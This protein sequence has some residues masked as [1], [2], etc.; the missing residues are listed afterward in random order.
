MSTMSIEGDP[1]TLTPPRA[2]T[3]REIVG[4]FART[5]PYIKPVVWH[6]VAWFSLAMVIGFVAGYISITGTDLFNN[7]VL[8]GQRIAPAQAAVL[9]VDESYVAD[10][11]G[12]ELEADDPVSSL[13][14]GEDVVTEPELSAEQR[15]TVRNR[16]IIYAILFTIIF[17]MLLDSLGI[18][19]W[20]T[21]ISQAI[22]QNL[23]VK[24]I[25]NA[26]HLSVKHQSHARTG[27]AI[28][29]VFQD[30]RM[31]SNVIAT[32]IL[33]PLEQGF[34]MLGAFIIVWFF[35]PTLGFMMIAAMVPIAVAAYWWTPRIQRL[36][37]LSRQSNSNVTSRI[38][39]VAQGIRVLKANQAEDIALTRFDRDS[40]TALDYAYYLRLEIMLYIIV[41][42]TITALVLI[43]GDYLMADWTVSADPTFLGGLFAFVLTYTLWNLGAFQTARENN[44]ELM[45][46]YGFM[47]VTW[48]RAIDMA[49][50]LNRAY[51]LLDLKPGV[52]EKQAADEFPTPI[53]TV[54]YAGVSFSYEEDHPVL[55]DVNLTAGVGTVTAIVGNTGSGKSTLTSLLLRLYDPDAGQITI[56][57]VDLRDMKISSIRSNVSIALQ[58]NVLFAT[59]VSDNIGYA[60]RDVTPERIREAARIACA[61]EFIEEMASGYDTELGERGGKLSTGQRQRLSIARAI[62]RDTPIL[63]LDEP[64]ASL[65][66]ETEQKVLGNLAEWGRDRVLFVITHRLST[67]QGADQIAFLKDGRITEMGTHDELM[68]VADGDY[69][70]FV[71]EETVGAEV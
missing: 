41:I 42:S 69:R 13:D 51:Y 50:G 35:S 22:N 61:D 59:S 9:F 67:I 14:D 29:R 25:E 18:V 32:V 7:A 46:K 45:G 37:W 40:H 65:D 38:Q 63:I 52:E 68:A 53:N 24:M 62:V 70:A 33:D 34:G 60:A 6:V 4:L 15:K 43:I 71:T 5:W 16:L 19:F 31:I 47:F 30:S 44:G 8:N 17:R 49:M 66:A 55:R 20:E 28:Y 64:T 1:K 26:E 48:F 54:R 23:R 57:D 2:M 39:E 21:W 27:D 56:N 36:S 11:L 10:D 3:V 12:S 58:Q